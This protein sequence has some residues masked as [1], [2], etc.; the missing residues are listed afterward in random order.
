MIARSYKYRLSQRRRRP[1]RCQPGS[2]RAMRSSAC[3][4]SKARSPGSSAR[5]STAG[6]SRSRPESHAA[7]CRSVT[8]SSS[9]AANP[10]NLPR[11]SAHR[12]SRSR[13]PPSPYP[14]WL[15][16]SSP[17]YGGRVRYAVARNG[18]NARIHLEVMDRC[19]ECSRSV[20]LD[21]YKGRTS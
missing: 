9:A 19:R 5:R 21:S 13:Y 4:F 20:T 10:L 18:G 1:S 14:A 15:A 6:R 17:F 16:L 8:T 7:Q 2:G 12:R 11:Y 3:V